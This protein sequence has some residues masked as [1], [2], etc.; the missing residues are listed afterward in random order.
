MLF[1][2]IDFL[3]F[4]PIVLLIYFI[5]P[6]KVRYI[7]L[8]I[9]SYYFYMCWNPAY[10]VLLVISTAITYCCGL[11]TEKLKGN[12]QISPSKRRLGMK[13]SIAV[14]FL[15]NIGILIYFK[16]T[17]FLIDTVNV[18]FD[19]AHIRAVPAVDILLPVG[20]SFYTF[21]AL[22]YTIDVYRGDIEAERNPL[23]Y[24]LFVSFFPQL[25]AGP[26]ERSSNL[27]NQIHE[28][29]DHKLWDYKR[30]TSGLIMMLWGFF[31]KVVIADRAAV[32]ADTI[33]DAYEQYQMVGLMVGAFAFAIQIYCDFQGYSTIAIGAARVLGFD[34]MENFNTP[35]FASSVT[36][37]W[38]RWHVSLST[39]FR[40]YLYIPLGGNR[41]STWKHY[42]NILITFGVSGLWHGAD[43]TY[44]IWGILHGFY[45]IAEKMLAPLMKKI[46]AR[47]HTRTASFGYRFFKVVVTFVFVDIAWI[48][49]RAD[50]LYQA[51]HYIRRMVTC[52][53]WW[54]LFDQSIYKMG[55]D[56]REWNVLWI[57]L[58]LLLAV[59][60]L[61]YIKAESLC[62]FLSR[63]W[64]VFRWGI[65]VLLLFFVVVFGYYGPGFASA[66][67]IYFQF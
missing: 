1:N 51:F 20:I 27:L 25:V 32:V 48:F 44:V 33:F 49:F 35:Y 41:C 45:Q 61:R 50:S 47:C 16:Y 6:K 40:D 30:V 38:R 10:I 42:R 37:F 7:W 57:A 63:Q 9:A 39:W 14:C 62:E 19:A 8:L 60:L 66:Q 12:A 55:L 3:V 5:L 58:L 46:H 13:L 15:S 64:I 28:E 26:I 36:D 23:K 4:F 21:Q 53:D 22:G 34:L 24:A 52:R 18:L 2:S 31:I 11:V 67:F 17:N 59:D 65:L 56:V 54:S 29:A 43:W